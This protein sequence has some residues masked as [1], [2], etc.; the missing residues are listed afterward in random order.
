[1][2]GPAVEPDGSPSPVQP[3]Q[4]QYPWRAFVRTVVQLV[5]GLAVAVPVF[6]QASG[7]PETT[8][9]VGVALAVSAVIT[10]VMADP[11][12]ESFIA[13]VAPWLAAQPRG[14][15]AAQE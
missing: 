4:V 12:V 6:V 7:L 8:A 15:S 2:S 5:V 11:R 9:G 10:R 1:M 3:T 13:M 14:V